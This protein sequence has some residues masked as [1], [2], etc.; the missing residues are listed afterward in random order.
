[1]NGL[2]KCKGSA[3]MYVNGKWEHQDFERAI[4]ISGVSIMR[5]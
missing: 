5:N 4:F 1:M 3:H 2:R